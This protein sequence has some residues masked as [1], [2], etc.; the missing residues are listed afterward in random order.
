ML[1][2]LFVFLSYQDRNVVKGKL[3][4]DAHGAENESKDAWFTVNRTLCAKMSM[5]AGGMEALY[6]VSDGRR[7]VRSV[8][9]T[10]GDLV[11]CSII[12]DRLQVRSFLHLCRLGLTQQDFQSERLSAQNNRFVRM[13][14]ALA[15]CRQFTQRSEPRVEPRPHKAPTQPWPSG[16]ERKKR[17]KRGFTYPGT[18]WCGAGNMADHDDH[19]GR[20]VDGSTLLIGQFTNI[21]ATSI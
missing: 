2:V 10:R 15:T 19:L 7:S 6:Q 18:L 11:D 8:V 9:D 5:L 21:H 12:V 13:E 17:S 16:D 3:L 1:W 14:E 20:V 4:N